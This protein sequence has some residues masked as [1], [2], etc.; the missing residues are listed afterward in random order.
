MP[1][2]ALAGATV[3][4]GVGSALVSSSATKK[5]TQATTAATAN[6]NALEKDIYDQNKATLAPFVAAGSSVTPTISAALGLSGSDA[7]DNAFNLYKNSTGYNFRFNEGQRAMTSAL[8]SRGYL[9]SGEATKSALK[10]GQGLASTEYGNWLSA[11]T[12]QQSMGLAAASAQAGVGQNYAGAVSANN[13]NAANTVGNAA[14][15]NASN[16]NGVLGS[17]LSAFG[18]YQ[19]RGLQSSYS[20]PN[21]PGL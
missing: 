10:Y 15:S 21:T 1:I 5:A 14:L 9:D 6:S 16:I 8:G 7:A 11:V 2:G 19:G 12:G 20:F 3:V 18:M 17:A 4:A 13:T